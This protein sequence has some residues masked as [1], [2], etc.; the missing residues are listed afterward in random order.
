MNRFEVEEEE[1]TDILR[2]GGELEQ[3]QIA[4]LHKLKS[5]RDNDAVKRALK[6]VS[7]TAAGEANLMPVIVDAVR[8]YA[9]LGEISDAM[10]EQFGEFHPPVFV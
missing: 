4:K 2:I 6:R 7:E 8:V 1:A 3:R 10:R 5:T 9:T